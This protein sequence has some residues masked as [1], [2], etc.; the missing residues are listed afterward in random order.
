MPSDLKPTSTWTC[1][2]SMESTVPWTTSPSLMALDCCSKSS[3]KL[4]RRWFCGSLI[5]HSVVRC[6]PVRAPC[7]AGP[8]RSPTLRVLDSGAARSRCRRDTPRARCARRRRCNV[9]A[10]RRRPP[11]APAREPASAASHACQR[12]R[13]RLAIRDEDLAPEL[14]VARAMRVKSRKPVPA[15]SPALVGAPP[16]APREGEGDQRGARGSSTRPRRRAPRVASHRRARRAPPEV[17]DPRPPRPGPRPPAGVTMQRRA[18]EEVGA[19]VLEARAGGCPPSGASPTN[20]TPAGSSPGSVSA[21]GAFTLPRRSRARPARSAGA[22]VAQHARHRAD[23]RREHD[24]V[25]ARDGLGRARRPR[26]TSAARE[27]VAQRASRRAA[28]RRPRARRRARAPPSATEPPSRPRPT[29]RDALEAGRSSRALLGAA[30]AAP[31]R[32][33]RSPRAGRSRCARGRAGRSP[34]AAARSRLRAAAR[35]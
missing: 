22:S 33:A 24:Q 4:P 14:G 15:T 5:G 32:G 30:A 29:H 6:S 13:Q 2:P 28:A 21:S 23:R 25:R 27:R 11:R 20:W 3:A 19:R 35:S 9:P 34:P 17:L 26:S 16:S 7:L 8:V 12:P 1:S 18:L 10:L 31:S